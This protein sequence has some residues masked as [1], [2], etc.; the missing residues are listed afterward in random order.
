MWWC[1]SNS[2][3][4]LLFE[5]CLWIW[6][7]GLNFARNMN[8]RRQSSVWSGMSSVGD[9]RDPK[10]PLLWE[11]GKGWE[12]LH[13]SCA[14]DDDDDDYWPMMMMMMMILSLVLIT[15]IRSV[16]IWLLYVF[17]RKHIEQRGLLWWS[18]R[19]CNTCFTIC[20]SFHLWHYPIEFLVRFERLSPREEEK[21]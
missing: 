13:S 1:P 7:I 2:N 18:I 21:K 17:C 9:C 20:L 8:G 11:Q 6:E 5:V 14:S 4:R 3:Y 10:I 12:R 19:S 16:F 15:V